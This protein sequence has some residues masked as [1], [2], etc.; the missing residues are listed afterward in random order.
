MGYRPD[1]GP[2]ET[3]TLEEIKRLYQDQFASGTKE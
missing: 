1:K 2:Q 3:T